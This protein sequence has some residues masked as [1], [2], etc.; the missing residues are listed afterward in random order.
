MLESALK[1][2]DLISLAK[3]NQMSAIAMTDRNNTFGNL[4]FSIAAKNAGIQP[5]NGVI[6]HLKN[7]CFQNIISKNFD[8]D[9]HPYSEILI[10]AKDHQGYKNLLQLSSLIY[11]KNKIES[12]PYITVQDLIDYSKGLIVFSGYIKGLIG[13]LLLTQNIKDAEC[14]SRYFKDLLGDRFYFE[15]MRHGIK[16]EQLIE[17]AYLYL[18]S[19]C[20]IPIVATNNILYSTKSMFE[21]HDVLMCIEQGVKKDLT[22]RKS[23]HNQYYFKSSKEMCEIF[24]DIPEAIE[25]TLCIA[26]RCS[27]AAMTHDP[28]LPSFTQDNMTEDETLAIQAQKGLKQRLEVKLSK[29]KTNPT[30]TAKEYKEIYYNDAEKEQIFKEYFQRLDYELSVICKM[31]FAGYFL[32]VSDFIKWSKENNI[33]VGPGRGSGAGSIIAWSLLITDLDPIEYGLLFE[34][35]LNP[36]RVSMP[37]FDIDF[38]QEKRSRVIEYVRN[39]YGGKRVSQIITFGKMQAK[40]VIKDVSRVMNLPYKIANY[41]SDL[42]PFN[43]VKPV[44]LKQAVAEVPELRQAYGGQGL[45]NPEFQENTFFH[46]QLNDQVNNNQNRSSESAN[47][48]EKKYGVN[49]LIKEVISTALHLEGV[50]RHASTHAAGI[51]I[52]GTDIVDYVA[53]YKDP[54][55]EL[56]ILQYSMKYAELSGFI[57]FD[58]LGLQTLT[59]ID[60]CCHLLKNNGVPIDINNIPL[61]DTLTFKMLSD[62]KSMG[63]FQFEGGGMKEA[64]RR[65]KPDSINDLI[66]LTSLY[67]PGPM[68]NLPTYIECKHGRE[69]PKYLHPLVKHVLEETYGIMIYQEQVLEVAKILAGF[70]LGGADLLRRAMGKKIESEMIAQEELFVQGC[71][72]NNISYDSAKN[73]FAQIS[74]FAGYGFNKSHAAAYSI[75]SYQMAYLKAHHVVEFLI[76][77][78]N[79][80]LNDQSKVS[81]FIDEAKDYNIEI[82]TPCINH[83]QTYFTMSDLRAQNSVASIDNL[84]VSLHKKNYDTKY[85]KILFG[86]AGIKGV[87]PIV[88]DYIVSERNKSGDFKDIV[89]FIRR[90]SNSKLINKKVLDSLIKAGV[91]DCFDYNRHTLFNNV[92]ALLEYANSYRESLITNQLSLLSGLSSTGASE[93]SIVKYSEWTF[94]EKCMKE[95][96]VLGLFLK[97]HPVDL[98]KP[99]FTSSNIINKDDIKRLPNGSHIVKIAGIIESKNTRM[100]SKGRFITV[101]MSDSCGI[102]EATIFNNDVVQNYSDLLEDNTLVVLL[103]NLVKTSANV[104]LTINKIQDIKTL[105][106]TVHTVYFRI[107]DKSTLT[108]VVEFLKTKEVKNTGNTKVNLLFKSSVLI[109]YYKIYLGNSFAMNIEEVHK[110]KENNLD[111]LE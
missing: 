66:A 19:K 91:F 55:S 50:H 109:F 29:P 64:L 93:V 22:K 13:T 32:I 65:L 35:F 3:Y 43:A 39:K 15:V 107:E 21:S 70:S 53:L 26:Q 54:S 2:S 94:I 86:F 7:S 77:C 20:D 76:T 62:G 41:I 58:F 44:T 102:F 69:K 11:L 108:K 89:D 98:Y 83:S 46:Q 25:N 16:N 23:S 63:V 74:K 49:F 6:F 105:E 110:I 72:T 34:R 10:I 56:N 80:D 88:G 82:I 97:H 100:S 103:C 36:E 45:Y 37:D 85:N 104:K 59:V 4:E 9:K 67:R 27:Y 5:I 24:V 81:L 12:I 92:T 106:D 78:I 60:R 57:K 52:A 90:T 8:Y 73:I 33:A 87:S 48:D 96:E 68:E 42:V 75:I 1:I 38:C 99:Y 28:M 61:H 17:K 84:D 18:S 101:K 14:I 71:K 79:L 51:I 30:Q 95:F 40:A 47:N 31:N 111:F